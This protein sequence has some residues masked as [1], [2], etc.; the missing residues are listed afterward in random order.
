MSASRTAGRLLL[1]G[2]LVFAGTTHLTIARKAFRAQVPKSITDNLPVSEDQVVLGSGV[3][4][5]LLGAT[6]AS[7]I[8]RR[9]VGTLAAVFFTAIFPGNLA[10]YINKRSAFGL[11]TDAKRA[12]RLLGQPLLVAWTLWSTRR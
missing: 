7:G 5:I 2:V 12:G 6:I 9:A 8:K 4:E 10:Q 11:D 1:G 3:V